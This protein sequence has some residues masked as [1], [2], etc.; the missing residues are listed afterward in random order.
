MTD[1]EWFDYIDK[2]LDQSGKPPYYYPDEALFAALPELVCEKKKCKCE[3]CAAKE[4]VVNALWE[5]NLRMCYKVVR[6]Y[7][8]RE[9]RISDFRTFAEDTLRD[10]IKA[11]KPISPSGKP[12]RPSPNNVMP[13]RLMKSG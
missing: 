11:Y 6:S 13:T 8:V 7:R 1:R 9:D 2:Q 3:T 4:E 12:C 10:A 5:R